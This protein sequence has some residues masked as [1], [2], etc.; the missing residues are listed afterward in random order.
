MNSMTFVTHGIL[1]ILVLR[2]KL[3]MLSSCNGQ[4][5]EVIS[6]SRRK[7]PSCIG[8][9]HQVITGSKCSTAEYYD[10]VNNIWCVFLANRGAWGD[11]LALTDLTFKLSAPSWQLWKE[12]CYLS[13]HS[14]Q[15][16]GRQG[17]RL[18]RAI[19]YRKIRHRLAKMRGAMIGA[20][21]QWGE[22]IAICFYTTNCDRNTNL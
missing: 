15:S 17:W 18:E 10:W 22:S 2:K 3:N 1:C 21:G 7:A 13:L 5:H 8:Q 11:G 12:R 9:G 6:E 14:Q 16:M 4:G 19:I 20:K